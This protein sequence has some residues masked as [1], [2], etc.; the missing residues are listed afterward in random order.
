MSF[1]VHDL[2]DVKSSDIGRETRI[3]Q[4][5]IVLEGA[6]IGENCNICAHSYVE[7]DVIVGN[8][9]TIKNGVHLW[10]GVQI[11]DRVFIGP[12]ATFANDRF[13]R[14]KDYS[15]KYESTLI[16]KG[17]SI[18][19]N[20]TILPGIT[21][22]ENAIVGAGA[23]VTRNVP[24][25]AIVV[26]NPARITGYVDASSALIE[27]SDDTQYEDTPTLTETKVKNVTIH[28]FPLIRDIRGC[29]SA[30]EFDEIVPFTPK[31]YFLVFDVPSIET[32]GAHAHHLCHQFLICVKGSC[33]VLVDD[34]ENKLEVELSSPNRAVYIPPMVWG[35]QYKYSSDAVLLVFA[36]HKYDPDDYIR[37][38]ADYLDLR[39]AQ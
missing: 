3:W 26:G 15:K 18:G 6:K 30:G 5:C 33:S 12:N 34:G 7:N 23:V 25:N 11:E 22:S 20:A 27:T 37:N 1:F 36:S 16:R 38:Y 14:S 39:N 13:P 9:V 29:L 35:I 10:D 4:F 21:I 19:A 24:A 8:E 31:R 32:R 17:A 2:A 28:R